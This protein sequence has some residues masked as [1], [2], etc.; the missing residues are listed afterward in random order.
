MLS[1]IET[2][3]LSVMM[4]VIMAGMGASLTF[5]DFGIALRRPHGM[6]IGLLSQYGIMPLLAFLLSEALDLSPG[7]S[8]GLILIGCMPGGTTSNMFTYFSR[9]VLPLSILMTLCSTLAAIVMVPLTLEL[10]SSGIAGSWHI[11]LENTFQVIALLLVPTVLGMGLRKLNA[12]L[13]AL[14]E[15]V[16]ATGGICVIV[17]LIASWVPRNWHLLFDTGF[18]VYAASIGLGAL[19]FLF[20]Y[21]F[22]RATRQDRNTSRTIA[23]ETGIQNSPLAVLIALLSFPGPEQREVLLVP[24]LYSLFIVL[25]ATLATFWFRY[26]TNREELERDQAKLETVAD[27]T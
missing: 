21:L 17:F 3:L 8:I 26:L 13:G 11:P 22:A 5:K 18:S 24:I 27:L 7:I 12:N 14:A 6:L 2:K 1:E 9:G 23:L 25:G 4:I 15:L 19:G 10:Y 20:G 16:G